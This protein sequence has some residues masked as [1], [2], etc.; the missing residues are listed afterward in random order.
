VIVWLLPYNLSHITRRSASDTCLPPSAALSLAR[1]AYE[2]FTVRDQK[3]PAKTESLSLRLDPKTKFILDFVVRA[4]GVRVTDLV[5]RA[6]KDMADATWVGP[7][8]EDQK[9]WID[10]WHPEEGVRT[11]N[12]IMDSDVETTFDED[13]LAEFVKQH[14]EFFYFDEHRRRPAIAFIQVIWPGIGEYLD[15]WRDHKSFSRWETGTLMLNA[16][17]RAD[18][19]GPVWPRG[20]AKPASPKPAVT[21]G[22]QV[23]DL[24]D[25]IPF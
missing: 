6:I 8:N 7:S 23:N 9:R 1:H 14:W 10:Y 25:D 20:A 3:R 12:M 13:E 11:L 16:I 19:Q 2:A 18:M 15:H 22:T 24:D 5:G 21:T 4:K 17:K